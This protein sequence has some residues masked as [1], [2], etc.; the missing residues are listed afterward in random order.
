MCCETTR[1][2]PPSGHNSL[3]M[4]SIARSA[5]LAVLLFVAACGSITQGGSPQRVTWNT[6]WPTPPEPAYW[7]TWKSATD[8][9]WLG[10][11]SSG[12]G[13]LYRDDGKGSGWVKTPLRVVKPPWGSGWG[14]VT[15]TGA[16]YRMQGASDDWM[17][18]SGPGE[19]GRYERAPLPEEVAAAVPFRQLEGAAT[20]AFTTDE[21]SAWWWPF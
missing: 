13:Y 5:A 15:E 17:T 12:E 7:G 10:I 4:R 14:L 16:R 21:D 8:T 19:D 9:S 11:E 20:P 3:S 6:L 18:I 2:V 1:P